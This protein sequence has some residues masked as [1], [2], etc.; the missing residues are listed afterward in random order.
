MLT[1][2]IKRK[3][4]DMI[5]K[6]EKPEEY[7]D[8]TQYYKTRFEKYAAEP[9]FDIRFRAGYRKDSPLM[10]CRVSLFIGNGREE[11]GAPAGWRGYILKIN[12]VEVLHYGN[13]SL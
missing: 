2:P 7:R 6:R 4:F 10:Q 12:T 11:W 1:L 9:D 3:W 8:L 13:S 5:A